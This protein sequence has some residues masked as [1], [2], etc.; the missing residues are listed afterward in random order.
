[1][2]GTAVIDGPTPNIAVWL[3]RA[4]AD[5]LADALALVLRRL[6]G[7]GGGLGVVVSVGA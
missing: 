3:G 1:M 4:L 2:E 7:L 5:A 6:Q